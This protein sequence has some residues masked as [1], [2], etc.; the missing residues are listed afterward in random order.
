MGCAAK[1]G[2]IKDRMFRELLDALSGNIA[3]LGAGLIL[4]LM[5]QQMQTGHFTVGDFALF[6]FFLPWASSLTN[7]VGWMSASQRQL[8][9]SFDRYIACCKAPSGNFGATPAGLF[10]E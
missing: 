8:G 1:S 5:A 4:L 3:E 9:V 7:A 6:V 10:D 2:L